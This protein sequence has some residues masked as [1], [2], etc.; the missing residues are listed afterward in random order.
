MPTSLIAT[1]KPEYREVAERRR[2]SKIVALLQILIYRF[3]IGIDCNWRHPKNDK[4]LNSYHLKNDKVICIMVV[5]GGMITI[6]IRRTA[7]NTEN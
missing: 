6:Y 7:A 1:P 4:D 2:D 5:Q 3:K